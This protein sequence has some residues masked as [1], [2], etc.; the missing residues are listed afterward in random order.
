MLYNK[1]NKEVLRKQL[2][3]EPFKRVTLSFYRYVIID[4]VEKFRNDLYAQFNELKIFGRIYLA[5]E[6]IN[7]Q[8][9]VPEFSWK[10][11]LHLLTINEKLKDVPLK[12]AVEDDGKS[13]YKLIVRCKNKIVADGLDDKTFDVTNVGNHLNAEEFNQAIESGTA[14]VVDMRNHYESEV[15]KFE[16]AVCPDADT[17]RQALPKA[18]ES[19]KGKEEQKILL[20]C[21]GGIRCEKASA[22]LKHNGFRDVSQLYGGIIEY[23]REIKSKKLESRFHGKNFVFDDRLGEKITDEI[24]SECHQCG[25]PSDHHVNCYNP[26]CHLLFIQCEKCAEKMQGCCTPKC[27]DII[28]LPPEEQKK[29]RKGKPKTGDTK[30]IYKSRL[31]PN[32]KEILNTVS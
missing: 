27:Q 21:T 19:L 23:A 17:F 30:N 12:I 22:Y 20:Y 8:I 31:R 24:I 2:M 7:A 9:S 14:I 25:Q 4:D 13:F 32:L 28:N 15:G 1:V 16:N 29:L 5:H 11:F 3:E 26:D 10:N 6:G 18:L